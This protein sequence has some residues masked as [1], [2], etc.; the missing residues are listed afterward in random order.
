MRKKFD[1]QGYDFKY[2]DIK[3]VMDSLEDL[4]SEL[5][6]EGLTPSE[7]W[8]LYNQ[9]TQDYGTIKEEE[10]ADML[11]DFL[12]ELHYG[13]MTLGQ[14]FVFADE[15]YSKKTGEDNERPLYS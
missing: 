4:I 3:D 5:Y 7:F 8:A 13:D 11:R 15:W 9:I 1:E 12:N 6:N 14:F 2:D 10:F